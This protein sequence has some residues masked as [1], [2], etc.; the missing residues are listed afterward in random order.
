MKTYFYTIVKVLVMTVIAVL[1][2]CSEDPV[3]DFNG[4]MNGQTTVVKKELSAAL[5]NNCAFAADSAV[6]ASTTDAQ[7]SISMES[8]MKAGFTLYYGE[9]SQDSAVYYNV[10]NSVAISNYRVISA[11][12]IMSLAE[13][14]VKM[15][16]GN[17]TVGKTTMAV[18][19]GET[20]VPSVSFGKFSFTKDAEMAD[21]RLCF[22][23]LTG[24]GFL[25][26]GTPVKNNNVFAVPAIFV[27]PTTEGAD[28]V[29]A[30]ELVGTESAKDE[31]IYSLENVNIDNNGIVSYDIVETHTVNVEQNAR[32]NG[33]Q[34]LDLQFSAKEV[35]EILSSSFGIALTGNATQNYVDARDYSFAFNKFNGLVAASYNNQ[36]VVEYKGQTLTYTLPAGMVQMYKIGDARSWSDDSYNYES[37]EIEYRFFVGNVFVKSTVQTVVEKVAKAAEDNKEEEKKDEVSIRLTNPTVN[38]DGTI[39]F[40]LRETH[41]VKTDLNKTIGYTRLDLRTALSCTPSF[42]IKSN[43]LALAFV[44]AQNGS[45]STLETSAFENNAEAAYSKRVS[46]FE[47]SK[48]N[49]NNV[50]LKINRNFF[51][52]YNGTKYEVS[53]DDATVKAT[54][55]QVGQNTVNNVTTAN[56]EVTYVASLQGVTLATATQS[57]AISVEENI[58]PEDPKEPVNPTPEEPE[59]PEVPS[60]PSTFDG[61]RLINA[62]KAAHTKI[63]TGNRGESH[64]AICGI[65]EK[66]SNPSEK[67]FAAWID[68]SN[69]A[70]TWMG[71]SFTVADGQFCSLVIDN[72]GNWVPA[73]LKGEFN[74]SKYTNGYVYRAINGNEVNTFSPFGQGLDTLGNPL[75]E[76]AV[77]VDGVASVG[78]MN[79]K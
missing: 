56:Y 65:F 73:V 36:L 4:N 40:E 1:T 41:T 55:S 79:L 15:E 50:T 54:I 12:D 33:A 71:S 48:Y 51:V 47:F 72:N 61:W 14:T 28:M 66:I 45:W 60:V 19:M 59:T 69:Q 34:N 32:I 37:R 31:V 68:G 2:S 75:I 22:N 25:K 74:G 7:L 20:Y 35:A 6:K 18:A 58:T 27:F 21:D 44:S 11:D 62:D 63:Y 42:N 24:D 8:A 38:N 52:I 67:M 53:L 76:A 10:K 5:K 49:D 64:D 16:N 70:T 13:T 57:V 43:D 78:G 77:V 9:A 17:F 23:A 3:L 29:W 46:T 26:I 39:S 30:I